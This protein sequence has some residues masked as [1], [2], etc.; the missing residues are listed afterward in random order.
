MRSIPP[1]LARDALDAAP[2][3]M[4]ILDE[5]GAILFANRQSSALFGYSREEIGYQR[6]EQLVPEPFEASFGARRGLG[7]GARDGRARGAGFESFAQRRD[8]SEF[9]IEIRLSV[10]EAPEGVLTAAAIRDISDHKRAETELIVARVLAEQ[11]QAA[12]DAARSSADRANQAKGRFLATASHDLRQPLQALALLN[13]TLRTLVKEPAARSALAQQEQTIHAMSRLMTALLDISKLESGAIKPEPADFALE[14]MFAELHTEFAAVAAD[15]GLALRFEEVR[16]NAHSDRSLVEEVMRN[17]ISNAI[18]YTAHGG[19]TVRAVQER[20]ALRLDVTDTGVGIPADQLALIFEEFFQVGVSPNA[21]REGY[22]LGLSIVQRIAKLLGSTVTVRSK[23]GEGSTFSLTVPFGA[24]SV[25]ILAA[26]KAAPAP[27]HRRFR[28]ARI[29]LVEDDAA[30]RGATQL[31]LSVEGYE[32]TAVAG[33]A[34]AVRAAR[35]DAALC[36][37]IT[38]YHLGACETG[39]QVI[40]AVRAILG[41]QLGAVLITG[42]TS[43]VI[44]HLQPDERLRIVSKP[45]DADELLALLEALLAAGLDADADAV[46]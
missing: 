34:D 1:E 8:G 32:V 12:A 16:A 2:D 17:L 42:D 30:V 45:V 46:A 26:A 35:E 22:G 39:V 37:L 10:I 40:E 38:D 9:P 29:L 36:L 31:L 33:L 25:P 5:Q 11:A 41:P 7:G 27:A 43:S 15:K 4:I 3:A 23:P 21:A 44:R 19:I 20:G 6:F 24:S 14:A 13:R 18:K 28:R